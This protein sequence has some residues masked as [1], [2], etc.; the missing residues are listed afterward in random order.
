MS[1]DRDIRTN[2]TQNERLEPHTEEPADHAKKHDDGVFTKRPIIHSSQLDI[3]DEDAVMGKTVVVIGSGAS[4]IEAVENTLAKGAK[5]TVI[6]AREDK[7]II[8]QNPLVDTLIAAHPFERHIPLSPIWER[9]VIWWNYYGV[10]HMVPAHHG[11]YEGTPVAN[12]EFLQHIRSGKCKYIRGDVD[13]LTKEGV[14][15]NV[16][17]RQSRPGDQC[18]VDEINADVIVLATGYERPDIDFLHANLFPEGYERPNL[19]LQTFATEDWSILL[20]DSTYQ[21]AIATAGH[22][23]SHI[24]IYTRILLTLL[25]DKDA[26]PTPKGMK[27]WVD[28][29]RFIKRGTRT[30]AL[31]FFTYMESYGCC[32]FMSSDLVDF[33]GSSLT[34]TDGVRILAAVARV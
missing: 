25:M 8:P 34:C 12:D 17:M 13:R 23:N 33:D 4:A 20:T 2:S 11:L 28:A 6:V 24:G 27:L 14:K 16:R 18:D 32:S 19:Y 30:G 7:W 3:L 26:R 5:G 1:A 31:E 29:L 22:L 10:E 15:V 9:I 21:D